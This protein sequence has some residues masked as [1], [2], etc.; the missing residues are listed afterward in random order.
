MCV[1]KAM[2]DLWFLMLPNPCAFWWRYHNGRGEVS[3]IVGLCAQSLVK[4]NQAGFMQYMFSTLYM[5]RYAK[6]V[7]F[8]KV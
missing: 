7:Q 2:N 3:G 4:A 6:F 1:D 8:I 5:N